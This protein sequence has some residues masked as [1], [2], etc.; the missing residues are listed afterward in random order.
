MEAD[1]DAG[2]S[3]SAPPRHVG[4]LPPAVCMS[5]GDALGDLVLGDVAAAVGACFRDG[6]ESA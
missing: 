6:V 2:K 1:A 5:F 3:Y 4:R